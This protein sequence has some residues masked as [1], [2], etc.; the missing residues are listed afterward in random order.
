MIH[1]IIWLTILGIALL[2][3]N[4]LAIRL[5]MFGGAGA[6]AVS[7]GP[8]V[9]K[10]SGGS[11]RKGLRLVTPKF[12]RRGYLWK[13]LSPLLFGVSFILGL[14]LEGPVGYGI[15][16][17]GLLNMLFGLLGWEFY[18]PGKKGDR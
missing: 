2:V 16:A 14:A 4:V 18:V 17:A 1:T 7:G 3:P 6:V 12:A 15:M 8:A 5:A 10:A 13:A 11:A 9:V